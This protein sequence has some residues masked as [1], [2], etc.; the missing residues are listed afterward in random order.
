MGQLD[1]LRDFV[2]NLE[3]E[4]ISELNSLLEKVKKLLFPSLGKHAYL[5][6]TS[7]DTKE[8]AKLAWEIYQTCR[9]RISWVNSNKANEARKWRMPQ[10]TVN[11]DPPTPITGKNMPLCLL[12]TGRTY[13][14][15]REFFGAP[16]PN[17][18]KA[19]PKESMT[20]YKCLK[21]DTCAFAWDWYNVNGD[22]ILER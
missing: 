7:D 1:V 4:Y 18:A 17:N 22:C 14:N 13:E 9:Y 21:K 3:T 15:T 12:G 20:C 5:G 11:F 6:I 16:L 19:P 2:G 8:T 10:I